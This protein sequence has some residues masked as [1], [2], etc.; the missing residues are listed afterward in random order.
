[1]T[2]VMIS[3]HLC[4]P[5]RPRSMTHCRAIRSQ[6]RHWLSFLLFML[7]T[8]GWMSSCTNDRVYQSQIE[9]EDDVWYSHR[10]IPFSFVIDDTSSLYTIFIQLRYALTILTTTYI[11]LISCLIYVNLLMS[12]A[13]KSS[14]SLTQGAESQEVAAR[15]CSSF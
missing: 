4:L 10:S 15:R 12:K 13:Y 6:Q 11:C 9:L 7:L 14:Y 8:F 1:M 2:S 3:E 5:L